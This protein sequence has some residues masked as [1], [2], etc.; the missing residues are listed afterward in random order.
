MSNI[1][2]KAEYSD[3]YKFLTS[4]GLL[5]IGLSVLLPWLF[6]QDQLAV[7]VMA[8]DYD[9]MLCVSQDL[10]LRKLELTSLSLTIVVV[11]SRILFIAGVGLCL[12]G[13]RKWNVKQRGIDELD[14]LE[15]SERRAQVR[16]LRESEYPAKAQEEV[17]SETAGSDTNELAQQA[18]NTPTK[19]QPT[20][21]RASET[22]ANRLIE[23]E[24]L[25]F[26]R[27]D[28]YNS[29]DYRVQRNV[30]L[31]NRFEVDILLAAYNTN[32]RV[33]K[34]IEI[35]YFQNRLKME[36]VISAR[37]QLNKT[38]KY[39]NASTRRSVQ[40]I[41]LLVYRT[42]IASEEELNRFKE[43]VPTHQTLPTLAIRVLSDDEAST[44]DIKSLFA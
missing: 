44:F 43:T 7:Q 17:R 28:D 20:E 32:Q 41:L 33:D 24:A 37:D 22:L 11:L 27:I 14:Q 2:E 38:R 8:D 19:E 34:L 23:V 12:Y 3:L 29:F 26:D 18:S 10:I 39:Y 42:G 9:Q 13:I 16:P 4:I 1:F 25:L 5:V 21:P 36:T 30:K 15:L 40:A 35:K 31:A 6:L